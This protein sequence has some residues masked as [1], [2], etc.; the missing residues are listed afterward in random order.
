MTHEQRCNGCNV[1]KHKR[2]QLACLEVSTHNTGLLMFP[3][4]R[5]VFCSLPAKAASRVVLPDPG[6]PSS[7][8]MRPGGIIALT[9]SKMLKCFVDDLINLS[10]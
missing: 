7:R 5:L 9:S 8:V 3:T 1:L 10:F 2:I 6:G 4:L